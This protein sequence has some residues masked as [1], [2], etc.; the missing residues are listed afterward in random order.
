[1]DSLALRYCAIA[2]KRCYMKRQGL[3][4]KS[5]RFRMQPTRF[6]TWGPLRNHSPEPWHYP[7]RNRVYSTLPIHFRSILTMSLQT[8]QTSAFIS[9]SRILPASRQHWVSIQSPLDVMPSSL[10]LFLHH[11]AL[12]RVRPFFTLMWVS[13][14]RQPLQ[15]R[16]PAKLMKTCWV[17]A[18]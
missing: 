2:V 3:R 6:L 12:N 17:N 8:R 10:V 1:M 11:F 7:Y 14:L 4:T 16:F 15:K 5:S 18:Y 9:C 13:A